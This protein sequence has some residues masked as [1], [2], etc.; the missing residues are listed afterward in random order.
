M[1]FAAPAAPSH[2]YLFL[3]LSITMTSSS[4]SSVLPHTLN[5][6]SVQLKK[7]NISKVKNT[8]L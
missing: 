7:L 1:T 8:R 6:H 5:A 4:V 2:A 3:K